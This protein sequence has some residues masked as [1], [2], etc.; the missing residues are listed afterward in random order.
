MIFVQHSLLEFGNALVNGIGDGLTRAT[1]DGFHNTHATL[2]CAADACRDPQRAVCDLGNYVFDN[3]RAVYAVSKDIIERVSSSYLGLLHE[4]HDVAAVCIDDPELGYRLLSTMGTY[5]QGDIAAGVVTIQAIADYVIATAPQ[6]CTPDNVRNAVAFAT[7]QGIKLAV[8]HF[9]AKTYTTI[10]GYAITYAA[11]AASVAG[12]QVFEEGREC[13]ELAS[14]IAQRMHTCIADS[15]LIAS[16]TKKITHYIERG[17][18]LGELFSHYTYGIPV[19]VNI[20][21]TI[22]RPFLHFFLLRGHEKRC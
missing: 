4:V 5:L 13:F 18:E 8:H 21:Q 14:N 3:V 11:K 12:S 19:A 7:E 22:N 2:V 1:H 9:L 6:W 17:H 16:T 15:P 10:A 20:M